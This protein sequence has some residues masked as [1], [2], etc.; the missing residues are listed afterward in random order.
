MRFVATHPPQC[1]EAARRACQTK[2]L[3]DCIPIQLRIF[4]SRPMIV[5]P[6]LADRPGITRAPVRPPIASRGIPGRQEA[7]PD[8][9]MVG[10][11]KPPSGSRG[12][13]HGKIA[14]HRGDDHGPTAEMPMASSTPSPRPPAQPAPPRSGLLEDIPLPSPTAMRTQISRVRSV[15]ETSMMFSTPIRR[16]S[17][18]IRQWRRQQGI[19]AWST[20][21][22]RGCVGVLDEGNSSG[23]PGALSDAGDLGLGRVHRVSSA[24]APEAADDAWLIIRPHRGIRSE[25]GKVVTTAEQ[26]LF[27]VPSR[28]SPRR[29]HFSAAHLADRVGVRI[30]DSRLR[31][32]RR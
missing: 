19:I 27:V 6:S 22:L 17:S 4:C 15:T 25:H 16:P 11:R 1:Q 23:H 18:A 31:V 29:R 24:R 21:P 9:M 28:R 26:L 32:C 3:I 20:A 2:L 14:H 13:N 10:T 12:N 8:P 30:G 7:E 5:R